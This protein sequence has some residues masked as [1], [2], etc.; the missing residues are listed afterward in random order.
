MADW[1]RV[2]RGECRGG[3]GGSLPTFDQLA[4]VGGA[5]VELQGDYV[6]LG[7]VEELNWDP[8]CGRHGRDLSFF[9]G[10]G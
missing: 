8:N 9:R 10:V 6:T 5:G 2:G 3:D 7:L 1:R 4:A